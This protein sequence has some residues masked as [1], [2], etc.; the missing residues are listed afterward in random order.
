M[1]KAQAPSNNKMKTRRRKQGNFESFSDYV[2][3]FAS[4]FNFNEFNFTS[5]QQD[6]NSHAIWEMNTKIDCP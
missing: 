4:F 3:Y 1:T 2:N 5:Q 6:I